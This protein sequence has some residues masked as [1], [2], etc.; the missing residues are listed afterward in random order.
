MKLHN[1]IADI[2]VPDGTAMPEALARTTH[3]CIGAHQDDQEFIALH[4]ILECYDSPDAWFSGVVLTDGRGSP[5]SG[6]Y[7]A[8]TD[9]HMVQTRVREQR[10]AARLGE[11]ACQAQLLYTSAQVKEG[12]AAQVVEDLVSLLNV[13]RPDVV[14]LHNPADKHDTHVASMLRGID[15]LRALPADARPARVYGCECWRSLDWLC[16]DAKQVLDV[17]RH[18]ELAS[19]LR[20]VFASQIGGGKRYDLAI[21]G[22]Y[23]TNATMLDSH[24]T[25]TSGAQAFAMDLSPLVHDPGLSIDEYVLGFVD[26]FRADVKKRLERYIRYPQEEKTP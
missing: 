2:F 25:D 10:E 5:R 24:A 6:P 11:Y 3:L 21:A 7:A 17:D 1:G 9:E 14:Y 15:A 23:V 20:C 19:A 18:H 8:C 16:D 22:R 4:G 26:G 13:A 12:A